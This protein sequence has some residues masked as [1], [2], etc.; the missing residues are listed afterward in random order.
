MSLTRIA[1]RRGFQCLHRYEV[2]D[3]PEDRNLAEFGACFT[4]HG[5]GHNYELEAYFEGTIDKVTGMIVNLA[6]IDRMLETVIAPLEGK[7]LNFEVTEFKDTV[8]TTEVLAEYLSDKLFRTMKSTHRELRLVKIR[9]FESE[10]LWV[11]VWP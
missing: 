5:H 7:H 2:K 11:D 9:L 3:W 10:D 6:D 1:R 8:P 4:P